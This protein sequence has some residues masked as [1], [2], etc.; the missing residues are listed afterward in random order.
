MSDKKKFPRSQAF[1]VAT[2]LALLLKPYV[3]EIIVA[4]SLRREKPFVGDI[5][6]LYIPRIEKVKTGLFNEDTAP[7]NHTDNFLVSLLNAEVIEKRPNVN[8]Q[9]AWGV[10]NKLSRH[11]SSGIPLDLF[12]T[13][14]EN[15]WVSLVVRTGSK[16]TNLRLTMGAQKLGRSLIA[17]GCGVRESDGNVI[18]ATSEREVFEL[19]GVPYLEPTKR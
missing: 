7:L 5:E 17:Y 19:C 12:A 9:F 10:N 3:E 14:R 15:W 4:G 1:N 6:L 13:T 8:G 2:E 18:S 16:E 11:V